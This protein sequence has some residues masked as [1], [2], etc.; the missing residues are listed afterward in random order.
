MLAKDGIVYAMYKMGEHYQKT[1]DINQAIEW[2][3]EAAAKGLA[4]AEC[5]LALLY[6]LN[7]KEPEFVLALLKSAA[8]KGL[9]KAQ[10][11]LGLVFEREKQG[12]L[13]NGMAMEW[14]IASAKNA[15][16]PA[17]IKLKEKDIVI[18][19]DVSSYVESIAI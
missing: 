4:C 5:E 9:D 1:G 8:S 19:A 13:V 14:F 16:R 15:Y 3:K 11:Q 10:Y 2:Y 17:Y 6:A 12:Q 7:K 18:H